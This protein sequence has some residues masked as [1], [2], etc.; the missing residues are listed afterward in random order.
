MLSSSGQVPNQGGGVGA[1]GAQIGQQGGPAGCAFST[2]G[3][4]C[5]VA[6]FA[7]LGILK[8][9]ELIRYRQMME[10]W[11]YAHGEAARMG[12]GAHTV[13][14]EKQCDCASRQHKD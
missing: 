3:V 2:V 8:L 9:I 11:I 1:N 7:S 5:T 14:S 13:A 10:R 6:L 12:V 4:A